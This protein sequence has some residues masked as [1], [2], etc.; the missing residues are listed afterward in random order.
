MCLL[1]FGWDTKTSSGYIAKYAMKRSKTCLECCTAILTKCNSLHRYTFLLEWGKQKQSITFFSMKLY[2]IRQKTVPSM[3][4]V[5]YRRVMERLGTTKHN[6]VTIS[7]S[8]INSIL[9]HNSRREVA[10]DLSE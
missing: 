6:I 1:G 9:D 8:W 7:T 10:H 2:A 5:W 3:D 4:R